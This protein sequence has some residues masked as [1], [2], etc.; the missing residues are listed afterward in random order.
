[1]TPAAAILATTHAVEELLPAVLGQ[2]IVIIGAARLGG[3]V[4]QKLGQSQV[5]G[6]IAAGLLLGPSFFGRCFPAAFAALFPS[7]DAWPEATMAVRMMSELGLILLMFVVGLEFDF[8]HLRHSGRAA[9]A[10]SLMGVL[11]PGALGLTLAQLLWSAAA[12]TC[13]RLGFSLFMGV[14][15]SITAIPVLA[16]IMLELGLTRTRL[17]VL[18]MTAAAIDD[19]LGWTLLATVSAV[20]AGG[21]EPWA[22]LRMLALA[23]LFV[24]VA[25]GIVRPI[26]KRLL[27]PAL[28]ESSEELSIHALA[29][30]LVLILAAG[31]ATHAIGIHSIFGPFVVG[32][33][34]WD[35]PA[36]RQALG[37]RLRDFVFAFFVP[38]FFAYTGLRTDVGTLDTPVLWGCCLLVLAAAVAGKVLGCGWAARRFGGLSHAEAGCV[39]LLMNTRGLMALV[40]I[41]VGR[42]LHVIPDA[43]Y[44]MLVLMALTTTLMTAPLVKRLLKR[45][46]ELNSSRPR[47]SVATSAS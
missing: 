43:V 28:P 17:G 40:V 41:D 13:D 5:V 9:T 36:L 20:V 25:V 22:T 12:P 46:D 34:L 2:L 16:R 47:P 38:I 14:A 27:A 44:C 3:F 42:E 30:V 21:F 29:A 11:L 24:L 32:A 8:G 39:A 10:V 15:L 23:G 26:A 4:F 35:E 33:S 7:A 1:M 18:T 45:V 19:V 6:E 31:M 37:R